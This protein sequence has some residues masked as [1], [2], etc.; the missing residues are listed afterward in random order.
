MLPKEVPE[1]TDHDLLSR[2]SDPAAHD[3]PLVQADD[4]WEDVLNPFLKATFG[5]GD[6]RDLNEIVRRG[7]MGFDAVVRFV[8]YFVEKRGVDA[9]LFEGKL[10]RLTG[11]VETLM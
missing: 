11:Y 3:D 6:E 9:A 5:W 10:S 4:L 1:A 7:D 2:F 8:E